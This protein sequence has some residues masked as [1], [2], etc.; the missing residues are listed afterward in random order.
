MLFALVA[1]AGGAFVLTVVPPGNDTFY[2]RCQL[3]SLTGLHCP[4]CGT[5]RALHSILNGRIEQ[6]LA[7]NAL[8]FIVLPVVGWSLAQSVWS[9]NAGR[10]QH[11]RERWAVIGLWMLVVAM[12]LFGVLRNLPWYPFALLAPHEL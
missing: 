11:Q 1:A 5:T 8:A 12:V 4:G 10:Y 3:H 2:P 7:Y 9:W 6:A